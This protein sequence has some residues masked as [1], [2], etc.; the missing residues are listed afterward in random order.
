MK[1]RISSRT[2]GRLPYVASILL[3]LFIL[4]LQEAVQAGQEADLLAKIQKAAAAGDSNEV[5]NLTASLKNLQDVSESSTGSNETEVAQTAPSKGEDFLQKMKKAG[6]TLALAPGDDNP[7]KFAFAKDIQ[8]GTATVYTADFFLS[9]KTPN[10]FADNLGWR[11]KSWDMNAAAS[12]QGK[13]TSASDTE[14]DAW[15]F[16]GTLNG[17]YTFNPTATN[18]DN[19][20]GVRW[21]LSAKDEASRDFDF[22]RVG[23]EGSLTPTIPALA[24]GV[25]KG[26]KDTVEFRWRPFFGFDAGATTVNREMPITGSDDSLWLTARA[27]AKL[28]LNFIARAMNMN[29]VSLYADDKLVYLGEARASHNYLKTGVNFMFNDSVGFSL[30][31]SVG[32]DSPKFTNEKSFAGAFT[33]GF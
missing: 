2:W 10:S 23:A 31:Y 24:M 21:S 9:W 6:F 28:K 8:A 22:N 20:V 14:H 27:T 3:V 19:I 17:R 1:A 11:H 32:Q 7:A 5:I 12:V 13:L 18:I 30:D 25:F 26:G 29:E 4:N 16:R 33:I 15:R